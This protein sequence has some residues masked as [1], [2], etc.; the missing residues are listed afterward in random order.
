LAEAAGWGVAARLD[1]KFPLGSLGN[2]GGSGG[3]DAGAGLLGT[4][5][6]TGWL[7]LH[8][9]VA[10]SAFS[11]LACTCSL[12]PKTW[13]FT[14]ELSVA[15]SWGKTTF[16]I[17]DRVLSPLFPAGWNREP[18]NGDDGLLSS[19]AFADFRVHNQV[20]FAVRRGRFT[21]WFSE[22]FTPGPNPHSTL[23]WAW[24]SNAPDVLFGVSFQQPL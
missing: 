11:E 15:A 19:G 7:T 17:E 4:F 16:L 22:D 23:K 13:H 3:F 8:G 1:L 5:E 2:A 20:S 24:S 9:L 6:P 21:V 10:L 18:A 14:A 12:Q